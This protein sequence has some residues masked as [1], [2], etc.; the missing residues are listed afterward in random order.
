VSDRQGTSRG[1]G[2]VIGAIG[3]VIVM[4][5]ATLLAVV[6]GGLLIVSGILVTRIK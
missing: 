2:I 4:E 5:A 1:A 6:G 3:V